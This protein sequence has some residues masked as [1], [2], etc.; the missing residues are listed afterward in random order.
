MPPGIQM[1]RD[2]EIGSTV[3]NSACWRTNLKEAWGNPTTEARKTGQTGTTRITVS[4][5]T[6][7]D[8]RK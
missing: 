6:K 3:M 1:R 8:M 7:P 2:E 5:G 4:V